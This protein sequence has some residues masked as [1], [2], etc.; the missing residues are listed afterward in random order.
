MTAGRENVDFFLIIFLPLRNASCLQEEKIKSTIK[1]IN[2]PES[3]TMNGA[4]YLTSPALLTERRS[5]LADLRNLTVWCKP[6]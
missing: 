2:I 6:G 5:D 1:A 4:L 3:Q